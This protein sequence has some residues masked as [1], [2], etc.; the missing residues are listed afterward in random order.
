MRR[1]ALLVAIGLMVVASNLAVLFNLQ[2]RPSEAAAA[3]QTADLVGAVMQ[4]EDASEDAIL[5]L[6]NTNN[7]TTLRAIV[8]VQ[9]TNGVMIGCTLRTVSPG[10][11]DVVYLIASEDALDVWNANA[12][13]ILHVNVFGVP[14]NFQFGRSPSLAAGLAGM[15]YQVD[16]ETG[17]T[18]GVANMVGVNFTNQDRSSQIDECAGLPPSGPRSQGNKGILRDAA[19]AKW[20]K[21]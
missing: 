20:S 1:T 18:K 2:A 9:N 4:F 5:L 8:T 7:T 11:A 21:K 16:E 15:I 14:G 12:D 3:V 13:N 6:T 10:D 17:A 19:P